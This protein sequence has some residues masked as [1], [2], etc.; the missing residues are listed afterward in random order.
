M[1]SG[2][3]RTT[4]ATLKFNFLNL[5]FKKDYVHFIPVNNQRRNALMEK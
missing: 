5:T 3:K 4:I 2:H 1:V